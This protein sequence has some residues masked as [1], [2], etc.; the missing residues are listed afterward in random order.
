MNLRL[1]VAA[2]LVSSIPLVDADAFIFRR[3]RERR[4][5]SASSQSRGFGLLL[6]RRSRSSS[7]ATSRS[8]SSSGPRWNVEGRWN[9]SEQFIADHLRDVHG[10]DPAGMTKAQMEQAHNDLHNGREVSVIASACSP[11]ENMCPC[12]GQPMPEG[13]TATVKGDK[14]TVTE[15]APAMPDYQLLPKASSSCPDGKC[16]TAS[17]SSSSCPSGSCPTASSSSRSSGSCPTCPGSRSYSSR[18]RGLFRR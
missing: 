18:R 6:G 4:A 9:Y 3:L 2:L 14:I 17:S 8:A 10:F 15:E 5:A 16:P 12:C 1:A 11:Q 13:M 7:S